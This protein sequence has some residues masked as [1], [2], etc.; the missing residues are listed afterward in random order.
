MLEQTDVTWSEE[1]RTRTDE[2]LVDAFREALG[3][4]RSAAMATGDSGTSGVNGFF[5]AFTLPD[6][7]L[8]T[9]FSNSL[10]TPLQAGLIM[11]NLDQ[12]MSEA[13][14][15]FMLAQMMGRDPRR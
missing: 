15:M 14:R 12:H 10:I 13:K 8:F 3:C 6:G 2:E 5:V 11:A 9:T 4:A 7:S 1:V